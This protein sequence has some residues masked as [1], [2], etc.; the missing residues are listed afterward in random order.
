ML[1]NFLMEDEMIFNHLTKSTN[2]ILS[3]LEDLDKC[4]R[5]LSYIF[6][7]L[8]VKEED[9]LAKKNNNPSKTFL[10]L[11]TNKNI[12]VNQNEVIKFCLKTV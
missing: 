2:G 4:G 9:N 7:Y 6:I 3:S 12:Q 10:F 11:E 8:L 5:K 1:G